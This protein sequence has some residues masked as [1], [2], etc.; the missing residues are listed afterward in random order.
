MLG[1][2]LPL[3]R[4][5]LFLASSPWFHRQCLLQV[6]R[7]GAE[8]R[9]PFVLLLLLL[10]LLQVL[11]VPSSSLA[12]PRRGPHLRQLQAGPPPSGTRLSATEA[13]LSSSALCWQKPSSFTAANAL[14]G[15]RLVSGEL[16]GAVTIRCHYTPLS[17]NRH[18]RK[19]WCRLGPPTG[20]CHTVVS[21]NHYTHPG[22]R[23]RA[24]LADFPQSS[25]FVVRLS[26]LSTRDEGHYRC[27]IGNSNNALFFSVSLT[28]SAAREAERTPRVT[29][30]QMTRVLELNLQPDQLPN[31][32]KLQG[33]PLPPP[34]PQA[35]L[36]VLERDP[37]P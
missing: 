17:I 37:G 10:C 24:A 13:L 18:Q 2:G 33:D 25:V 7:P 21:T 30:I 20:T 32:K 28:V 3:P 36:P 35:S 31:V 14:K 9:I 4:Q 15:P 19:Y 27:G 6:A 12:P 1:P 8:W 34:P 11:P 5:L 23:G 22:Y 26:Q 16:G 29:L